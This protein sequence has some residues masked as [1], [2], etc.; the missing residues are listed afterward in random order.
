MENQ[1]NS[2]G[3]NNHYNTNVTGQ[4]NERF[5]LTNQYINNLG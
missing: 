3:Y 4:L 1:F 5:F 2:Y